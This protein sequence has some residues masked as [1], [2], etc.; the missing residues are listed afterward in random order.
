MRTLVL[1]SLLAALACAAEPEVPAPPAPG[2]K[3]ADFTLP[4][5]HDR[6]HSLSDYRGK[7]AVVVVFVG[8]ECPL[9]N[10]YLT[11]LA[12]LH[13][14]YAPRGVQFLA[15]NSND[16]D[17]ADDVAAHAK[18]RRIPFPVLK[19][20]EHQAADAL[21]ARRTPE[22]FLLDPGRLIRYHGRVDDQYGY[23]YRRAAP[24]RTELKD[25]IEELLAGKP[26]TTSESK[27]LGCVIGRTPKGPPPPSK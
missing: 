25:A 20:A 7:K 14:A 8:T 18:E 21:G 27:V 11:T 6:R 13:K 5:T 19:D 16:Q 22:A 17:S 15:I 12:D 3:V 2:A 10:L 9:G 1:G 4:D 26:I 24:S 23:S